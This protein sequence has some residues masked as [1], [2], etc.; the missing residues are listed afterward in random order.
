MATLPDTTFIDGE[1]DVASKV[2]EAIYGFESPSL[3]SKLNGNLDSND[4]KSEQRLS[5]LH[6][7]EEAFSG[8]RQVGGT[9]TLDFF[10]GAKNLP[11]GSGWWSGVNDPF[12]APAAWLPVPGASSKAYLPYDA[13]VLIVWSVTW[14]NDSQ[15]FGERSVLDLFV[16][17]DLVAGNINTSP[18]TR[19]INRSQF[20][21]GGGDVG[22]DRIMDR[23][24]GRS[25][26][27]HYVVD[28]PAGYH[29]FALKVCSTGTGK[30]K[31]KNTKIRARSLKYIYFR[32]G[33]TY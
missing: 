23:Y 18:T 29:D 27:G 21:N 30:N 17:D 32:Q 28:L 8:G 12:T 9:A 3:I 4:L 13:H 33:A 19:Q 7:Q 16:N 14:A 24:K 25:Y 22:Y 5:Y 1:L 10:A 2:Y 26:S 31:I 20:G 15:E 6:V 11:N